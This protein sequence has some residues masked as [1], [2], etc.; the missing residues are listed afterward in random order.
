MNT[1]KITLNEDFTKSLF[2][3]K[4]YTK[5][6]VLYKPKIRGSNYLVE[7]IRLNFYI[8]NLLPYLN[9]NAHYIPDATASSLTSRERIDVTLLFQKFGSLKPIP[10]TKTDTKQPQMQLMPVHNKLK[11]PIQLNNI[12]KNENSLSSSRNAYRT[13]YQNLALNTESFKPYKFLETSFTT[14]NIPPMSDRENLPSTNRYTE[15][16]N[17]DSDLLTVRSYVNPFKDLPSLRAT[18]TTKS[19]HIYKSTHNTS[20][21]HETHA[22]TL[23]SEAKMDYEKPKVFSQKMR[24]QLPLKKLKALQRSHKSIVDARKL[25]RLLNINPQFEVSPTYY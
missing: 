13:L 24:P 5:T 6:S 17:R 8:K 22:Q 9:M 2:L 20:M 15:R 18:R 25:P 23:R 21:V 14:R 1:P 4:V 16:S 19:I 7:I 10:E 3:N 11:I 12:E